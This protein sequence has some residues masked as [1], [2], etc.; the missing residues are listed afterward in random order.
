MQYGVLWKYP[1]FESRLTF[2][3]THF[4]SFAVGEQTFTSLK[5]NWKKKK[6][7]SSAGIACQSELCQSNYTA[8]ASFETCTQ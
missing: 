1:D 4:F 7:D 3:K 5:L 6:C 8:A 2:M